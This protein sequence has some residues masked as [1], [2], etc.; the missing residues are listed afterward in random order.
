MDAIRAD[1]HLLALALKKCILINVIV[2]KLAYA[3]EV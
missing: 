2:V 3:G 1:S